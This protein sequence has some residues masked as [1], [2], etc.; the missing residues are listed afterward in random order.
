MTGFTMRIKP[1]SLKE[2]SDIVALVRPGP[3]EALTEDGKT[4][5]T[6]AYIAR[7]SG[8]Q[9]VTYA[10]PDMEPILK[11][12]FGVAVYQEQLQ[13][14][15]IDLAGYSPE[16]ADY[17]REVLS[18]KKKQEMEKSLP[19][20]RQ[21]LK[22]RGWTE[23]QQEVFIGLCISSSAY[24]FNRSHSAAYG[25][26]GYW[27]A[28]LKHFFPLEWWTGVLL[29]A[30]IDDIKSEYAHCVKEFLEMPHINGPTDSFDLFD[31][32]IHA[33]LYL[34]DG[35]GDVAAKSIKNEHENHGVF[36]SLQNFFERIN[37]RAVN[38]TV[39]HQLIICDAFKKIEPNKSPKELL[40]EYHYLR[41]VSSIKLGE[42]K[43]GLDL[44]EAVLKYKK[45]ETETGH[46]LDVP[47]LYMS[48]IDLEVNRLKS[49][50]IYRLDVHK[51][52]QT[53]LEHHGMIID[54]D[55][56]TYMPSAGSPRILIF[57]NTKQI[58]KIKDRLGKNTFGWVGLVQDSE[59][60]RYTDRKSGKQVAAMKLFIA[61]DGDVIEAI[62]WPDT[63]DR[64]LSLIKKDRLIFV[65][66]T[67]KESREPGKWS[68]SIQDLS[69]L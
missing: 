39:F 52:F 26:V 66:G 3:L 10:H 19:E 46:T 38:Q 32:K 48:E 29:Y 9:K 18:K 6:E 58:E 36:S 41:K 47:E 65:S 40:N 34:I 7:K 45:K 25:S 15:F 20:L 55:Y 13:Q 28:F 31:G 61:N 53:A 30:K 37:K 33:P 67:V 22:D 68:I 4:T 2:L 1:T 50:P 44:T 42:G 8:L 43:S 23:A 11:D 14:M 56:T 12:T 51:N 24:S 62:L 5:M 27:C 60:F 35:I 49:M 59:V 16:D 69:V 21:R 64:Y 57:K 63:K 17:L 54:K